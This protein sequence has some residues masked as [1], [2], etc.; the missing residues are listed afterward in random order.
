MQMKKTDSK[1]YGKQFFSGVAVLALSTFIVKIIGLFYKIP[2]M[3]YLGAEGMGYFN[4]AYEIYSLFFIIAT[5]GIPV[6]ISILI[7]E[8]KAQHRINNI[9]RIFQVSLIALGVIGLIGMLLLGIYHKQFASLINNDAAA[10]SI[11]AISPTV[12]LI[13]LSSAVRGYFQGNQIMIPTA[14]SQVIEALGKLLLGLGFAIIAISKGYSTSEVAAFAVLGLTLGV[15]LSLLYLVVYKLIYRVRYDKNETVSKIVD[16]K[17]TILKQLLGIAIPITLSSTILSLTK[18]IDMTM[19]LGRLN[20]IGY[21]QEAANA[22]YGSYSTMAVSIYNLPATLISAIALPLVP[23]LAS[24]IEES[25]KIKEKTV[26]SSAIKLTALISFPAGLGISIFSKPILKLLFSSQA[27]EIEYTAPLLSLLGLSIFL[28]SMITITNAILQAYKQVNKPIISM[29]CGVV[30]K[31]VLAF[32]LIGVPKVNIYGAPI[33][34]FFS[35]IVIV[36]LNLYFILKNTGKISSVSKLFI[37]P[38]ISALLSVTVGIAVYFLI[39]PLLDVKLT[40]LAVIPVV[41]F[42]YAITIIILKVIDKEEILMLPKGQSI[43]KILN[44][45]HVM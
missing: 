30:I 26:V 2:M 23:M 27:E 15:G 4:S 5:A 42:I 14:V 28:S 3:A 21:S 31:L 34:T 20:A 17:S 19:I 25:D 41:A 12:L 32:I 9:K 22:I 7:S 43:I 29:I 40:I 11:L 36:A 13:C 16:T 24:A 18:I 45:I 8:S 44:K 38:F 1:N 37:K 6:A 10:L 39:S 33:S 35:T